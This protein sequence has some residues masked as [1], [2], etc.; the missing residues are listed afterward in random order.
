MAFAPGDYGPPAFLIGVDV[1]KVQVP[2]RGAEEGVASFL[3]TVGETTVS[4][5]DPPISPLMLSSPRS[6]LRFAC[7]LPLKLT[8]AEKRLVSSDVPE[9]VA[10]DRFYL[11]WTIK[12]AYTKAIGLGLGFD[13]SRIE[14]DTS[15][16]TV[17]VDGVITIDWRF[18]TSQVTVG[19]EAYR[20]TVAQFV[21]DGH[22]TGIVVPLSQSQIVCSGASY[23][24][25]K[26]LRQLKGIEL[27][28]AVDK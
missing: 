12:E 3:L 15:A 2:T 1:M 21:G 8:D 27:D 20:I 28:G 11:I 24:V 22:G 19:G 5:C 6:H 18:E 10:L 14:Y 4:V 23:F 7:S 17:A 13:L 9:N 25:R 16:N 26:A